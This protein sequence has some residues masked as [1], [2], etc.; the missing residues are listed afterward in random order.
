MSEPCCREGHP[1]TAADLLKWRQRE[2]RL[3]EVHKTLAPLVDDDNRPVEALARYAVARIAEAEALRKDA[4]RWRHEWQRECADTDLLL[5]GMGLCPSEY[6]SEGGSL[7]LG[8]IS[9]K[10]KQRGGL[11]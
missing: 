3:A 9:H 11:S 4:E 8:R 7:L 2:A 1:L 6:R 5:Q 10:L